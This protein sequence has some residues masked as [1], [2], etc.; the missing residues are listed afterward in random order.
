MNREEWLCECIQ[1]LRPDFELA[2]QRP[3]AEDPCLMLLAEQERP[4]Q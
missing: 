1:Q 2:W 4:G 3:A